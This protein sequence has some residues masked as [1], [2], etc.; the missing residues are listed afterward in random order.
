MDTSNVKAFFRNAKK[1]TVKHSPEILTG[2]GIAGFI[3]T[4]VLAVKATPK[5]VKLLEDEKNRQN[6]E[7]CRKAR[8]NNSKH[9]EQID[10]LTPM[11]VI[12]TTWKCYIPAAATVLAS[13]TCILYANSMHLKRYSALVTAY[14]LSTTA[15]TEY[16][17]KVIETIGEKKEKTVREKIS[18]EHVDQN[19]VTKNEVIVTGK[20]ESLFMDPLSKRYFKSD[21]EQINK[22]VN[23]LNKRMLHDIFGHISLSDFYDEIG[24]ERTDMS[25]DIGWNIE[26]GMIDVEFHPTM[27]DDGRPAL[28]LYYL[29]P[30]KWGYDE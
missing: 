3:T 1:K 29:N 12:K 28:A 2:I 21:I 17:D 23:M 22:I 30:P 5:A 4:T 19:P 25:D 16:K 13:A 20:G 26:K 14:Q 7:L 18:K 8:A 10:R 6:Y 24:L 27:S 11:E 9:C 15:L